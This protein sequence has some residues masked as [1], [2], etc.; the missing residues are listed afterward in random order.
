MESGGRIAQ[1]P[2]RV[3]R[4]IR[5]SSWDARRLASDLVVVSI[6]AQVLSHR[7]PDGM[8]WPWHGWPSGH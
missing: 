3:I 2:I 6:V 8:H 7:C 5:W 1:I 4:V